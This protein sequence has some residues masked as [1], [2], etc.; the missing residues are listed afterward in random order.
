M[1][2]DLELMARD[3]LEEVLPDDLDWESLVT[4]YPRC[5][6][7]LVAA[8]GFWLG[9]RHG[10]QILEALSAA[11]GRTVTEKIDEFLGPEG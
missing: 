5:C 2:Q 11:A 7:T 9:V 10:G 1:T 3:A 8:A 6:L 4:S